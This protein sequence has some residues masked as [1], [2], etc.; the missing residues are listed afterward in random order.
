MRLTSQPAGI[1]Q[2]DH[3]GFDMPVEASEEDVREVLHGAAFGLYAMVGVP[4]AFVKSA[5]TPGRLSEITTCWAVLLFASFA[6]LIVYAAVPG[7]VDIV[8]V[9]VDFDTVSAGVQ[10]A[11]DLGPA[12]VGF[13]NMVMPP[14]DELVP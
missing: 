2:L 11:D 5:G 13:W 8:G 3:S 9:V 14:S 10:A 1:S 6:T 7:S 12:T 4:E